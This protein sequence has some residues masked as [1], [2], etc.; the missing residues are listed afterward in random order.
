M[1]PWQ[2]AFLGHQALPRTLTPFELRY[3]FSFS[4]VEKQAIKSRR[5]HL[6]QLG[7]ALHLGFIKMSGRTLDAFDMVPRTLLAHLGQELGIPVPTLT[8]LRALYRRRRTLY[9]HQRWATDILGFQNSTER[10]RRSLTG[11]IKKES[12]KALTRPQ[13]VTFARS[14]CYEHKLLIPGDR[15]LNDLVRNAIQQAEHD[16]LAAVE[17]VVPEPVRQEWLVA[18]GSTRSKDRTVLE[19]LQGEPGKPSQA[20][21]RRQLSY[22]EYL[23]ELAVHDYPLDMLRLEHQKQLAQRIR[24]R[25]PARWQTLREPRRTL[26]SVCFLRVTLLQ[27]TDVLIS[28]VDRE[29][30]KL[31]RDTVEQ[32]KTA[33]A[34]LGVSLREKV[35]DLHAYAQAPGRTLGE[36]RQAIAELQPD[37]SIPRF[38]NR[39]AEVRYHMT[40]SARAVRRLLKALLILEFEGPGGHPLIAALADLRELY[41]KRVRHLPLSIDGTFAPIWSAVIEGADRA[42]ALRGYETAILFE[43]RKALRNGAIWVPHSLSYRHREQLLIASKQWRQGKKR[44]YAHLNLPQ[45]PERYVARYRKRLNEGLEQVAEAVL[46]NQVDIEKNQLVLEALEAEPTIADLESTR[47]AIFGEIGTVQFPELMMEVDSHTR[48]SSALL[49]REPTSWEELL[50]VYGALLAHGTD[51]TPTGMALMIPKIKATAISD[52]MALLENS[53]ALRLAND[54]CVNFTQR[55]PITRTWGRERSPPPIP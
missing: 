33:H 37:A 53:A 15:T 4:E 36:V 2:T 45:D 31:R 46:S 32:V 55:H 48:F 47:D 24:R 28:L 6:N 49:G 19:W 39:A 12:H 54:S 20:T 51:M 29:I 52:A 30:L 11:L 40:D 7:A 3:F 35:Q 42:R 38:T 9:E 17:E 16:L 43:L 10:Q 44:Y 34:K 21:L 50:S 5:R 25:R 14:W 27:K 13:L 41:D 8:S 23:K 1:Q 26:E 18:L 22:I